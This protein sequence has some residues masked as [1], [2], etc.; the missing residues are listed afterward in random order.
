MGKGLRG[1]NYNAWSKQATR[2]SST[3]QETQPIFIITKWNITSRNYESLCCTPKIYN[4]VHRLHLNNK[5]IS[6]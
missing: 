1:T 5:D 3:T 6:T 2:V 4:T